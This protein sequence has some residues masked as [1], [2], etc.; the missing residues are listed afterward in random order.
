MSNRNLIK[1]VLYKK[2]SLEIA[3]YTNNMGYTRTRE[4]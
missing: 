3:F 4:I 1:I 2:V